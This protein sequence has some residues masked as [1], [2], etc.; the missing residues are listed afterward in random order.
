MFF[1]RAA[2]LTAPPKLVGIVETP[3]V[4]VG[5]VDPRKRRVVTATRFSTRSGANRTIF[6]SNHRDRDEPKRTSEEGDE[7]HVEGSES[8]KS[9]LSSHVDLN[10]NSILPLTG[11]WSAVAGADNTASAD[12][13]GLKGM[14]PTKFQGLATPEKNPMSMQLSHEEVVVGCADGTIYVMNF[15]GYDYKKEHLANGIEGDSTDSIVAE[16][17]EAT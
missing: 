13:K 14:F 9:E 8:G 12:I 3:D 10:E 5:A 16:P 6:M 4:A 7:N 11:A 17:Q 15:V 2:I 1:G